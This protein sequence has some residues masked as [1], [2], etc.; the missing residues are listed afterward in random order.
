[1]LWYTVE[2][3]TSPL[4]FGSWV[5]TVRSAH[6]F[7]Y[8]LVFHM[9]ELQAHVKRFNGHYN[10]KKIQDLET[11]NINILKQRIS[12]YS[13]EFVDVFKFLSTLKGPKISK[14]LCIFLQ[15]KPSSN[16]TNDSTKPV[17]ACQFFLVIAMSEC[18]HCHS[19]RIPAFLLPCDIDMFLQILL[20]VLVLEPNT[21]FFQT[22][23]FSRWLFLSGS[24]LCCLFP[25]CLFKAKV[26]SP[27]QEEE[28]HLQN[29]ELLYGSLLN[30]ID[31]IYLWWP[32]SLSPFWFSLVM[33]DSTW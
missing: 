3:D 9:Q 15:R 11:N 4:F 32:M 21:F 6:L 31:V 8:F 18:D 22:L 28:L 19:R 24:E 2:D 20:K 29:G 1:M 33:V 26:H 7:L 17:R 13:N 23:C 12:R 16:I 5:A 14:F 30:G 27:F 25:F 10:C